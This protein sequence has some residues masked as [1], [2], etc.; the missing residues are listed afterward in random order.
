M[1]ARARFDRE[2]IERELNRIAEH[3]QTDVDAYLIGGGAMSLRNLKDTTKDIDLVVANETAFTRLMGTLQELG[4]EEVTDLGQEYDE[5][6][7]RHCV[8]NAEGCQLDLFHRQIA[9][10]LFF[11]DGMRE[12]SD[13]FLSTRHLSVGLVSLDDIFLFKSVAERPDDIGD[14]ATLVQTGLDFEAI[15]AEIATQVELL[16]GER[17][18]TIV[19][20]SLQRLDEQEGIQTPLDD[21]VH[22]YYERYMDGYELRVQLDEDEPKSITEVAEELGV[23]EAEIEQRVEYLAEYGFAERTEVGVRDT[24]KRDRF[25]RS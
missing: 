1:T 7:A 11:S 2:Y 16:G 8:R 12:R 17:F 19:A 14:M 21:M 22:D 20:E 18:V 15:E 5:L 4:Y 23:T 10:K 9:D 3:L 13:S 6:G 24:G 25:K